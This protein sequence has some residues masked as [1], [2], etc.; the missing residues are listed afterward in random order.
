MTFFFFLVVLFLQVISFAV[1]SEPV[2]MERWFPLE[3]APDFFIPL[4]NPMTAEKIT[5]GKRLFFDKNLSKDRS[6]SCATCHDPAQGF[7]NGEVF[8]QGVGGAIG[9]RNVP[10]IVNRLLGRTQFW[11]GRAETLE[12]QVIEPLFNPNEMA[13]NEN[14][15]LE[16]LRA[17][18][19]Y[20][21][22]F[23]KAFDAEPTLENVLQAIATFER[24]LLSRT[25]AFDLYEWSGEKTAL[26]ASAVRGL[27]LFRGKARC[28]TCHIGT[29]FTDERF[30]NLGAGKGTGQNDPGRAAVTKDLEDFG[31]FKTP[32]L[33]NITRTA[34]YMH[35]GSLATLE[36]VITFYDRGGRP[37]PNLDREIKP[38]QLTD[39][40]RADLLEF[41]KSLTSSV[42]S[43]SA[44]E[45]KERAR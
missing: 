38:L 8:A 7:S 20:P 21:R 45:L 18:T 17:D 32:T 36:D 1:A 15:L 35:D 25:T 43:V 26:S 44:E 24:T 4:N 33:R 10:S 12:L 6:I 27:R 3:L 2:E 41:L 22:L 19:V 16:R 37:N 9:I 13:M 40:E 28:S 30:H 14:L 11:D 42:I 5:L 29:N 23:Q 34:P 31:K 39:A